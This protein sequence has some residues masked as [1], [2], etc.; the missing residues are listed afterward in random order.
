MGVFFAKGHAQNLRNFVG[1]LA[2]VQ[3]VLQTVD[4]QQHD[5]RDPQLALDRVGRGAE[6]RLDVQVLLHP[7]EQQLDPPPFSVQQRDLS[8]G[9]LQFVGEEL[10]A[11][12][13]G[14]VDVAHEPRPSSGRCPCRAVRGA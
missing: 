6:K 11:S 1:G 9:Q 14:R 8:G 4:Q 5:D 3:K 2:Q 7:L 13:A 10:E 12:A